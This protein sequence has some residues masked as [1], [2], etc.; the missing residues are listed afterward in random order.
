LS[1]K[2][3]SLI[4]GLV[5]TEANVLARRTHHIRAIGTK[6]TCFVIGFVGRVG[7]SYLQGLLN[8]HPDVSCK[9]EIL[10]NGMLQRSGKNLR[11]YIDELV[12]NA[13][14]PVNG[15]KLA[16]EHI[17]VFPEVLDVLRE[18]RYRVIHLTRRNRLDQFISMRLAQINGI[19]RSD[20]GSYS[21]QSFRAEPQQISASV[22]L[23]IEYDEELNRYFYDLP[24]L[25][26]T[27][28]ELVAGYG[29][30]STFGFLGIADHDL[31]SPYRRQRNSGGQREAIE[32]FDELMEYFR[33]TDLEE[34]FVG[35]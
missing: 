4:P 25:R 33:G 17:Q 3:I 13:G 1:S 23:L 5:R 10:A 26:L 29:Y 6:M 2:G 14:K 9:G 27:Y 28:E 22:K 30:R 11:P 24:T 19:W 12:H 31:H 21:I 35:G 8:N 18:H 15:Y 34:Y 20:F 7:S 16:L 32:N